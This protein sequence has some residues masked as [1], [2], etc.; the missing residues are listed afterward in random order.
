MLTAGLVRES[1]GRSSEERKE[2][3]EVSERRGL[4]EEKGRIRTSFL[5]SCRP[6]RSSGGRAVCIGG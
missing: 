5:E 6:S 4:E 1:W 3:R 2:L